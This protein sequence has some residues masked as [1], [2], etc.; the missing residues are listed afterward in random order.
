MAGRG[1]YVN[2]KVPELEA[3]IKNISKYDART[4]I[5]MESV[6]RSSTK[7]IKSGVLKRINDKTGY[8]RKHTVDNFNN[9]SLTGVV[10]EKAPH[11]HLVEFGHKGP[12]PAREHPT[13]RPAF[14]DEKPRLIKGLSEA[15]KP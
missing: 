7:S 5:K 10:K 11:A 3:A 8:L 2:F 4:R 13:M 15:V 9:K 1:F 12:N 6:I 14:E